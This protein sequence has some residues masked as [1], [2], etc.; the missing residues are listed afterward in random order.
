MLSINTL[1]VLEFTGHDAAQFLHNQLSAD[2][3]AIG[4]GKATFAC[5]CN[6]AGRVLGLLLLG[7]Q[8]KSILVVCASA[9]ATSLV[10][11]LSKYIIRE[12]V[13]IVQRDDLVVAVGD[14]SE[15][16]E[17]VLI[18]ETG[19]GLDYVIA[20]E[21]NVTRQADS[22]QTQAWK[23]KELSKGVIWLDQASS[24]KFLPQMLG[25]ENIGALSFQKGCF[26]G[27][28]IIARTRYLGK[29]KRRP[30]LL[31]IDDEIP[32]EA[33]E[34]ISLHQDGETCSAV[35]VDQAKDQ[36]QLLFVV[37]RTTTDIK[38]VTLKI[39]DQEINIRYFS[40]TI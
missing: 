37:V 9:L 2:I 30:M 11:M 22:Q 13:R 39:G 10:D 4:S 19:T 34:K 29:L 40:A 17:S 7:Q 14:P 12:D 5:Y 38:P 32:V 8:E 26:P 25:Y 6:P 15:K 18:L 27:Q 16:I 20:T 31:C 3:M 28:E 36:E 1:S 24:A 35:I 21:A 23:M 33:N